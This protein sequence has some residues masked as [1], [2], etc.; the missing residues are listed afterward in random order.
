MPCHGEIITFPDVN[1][2]NAIRQK[3]NIP[4]PTP[5]TSEDMLQLTDLSASSKNISDLS[6]LEYAVNLVTLRLTYNQLNDV[7]GLPLL[8]N[9][10][11]LFLYHNQ[12]SDLAGFPDYPSLQTLWLNS[13]Q[14]SNAEVICPVLLVQGL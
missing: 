6:G 1:L 3:L 9:L 13:N 14:I 11:T 12:F 2:E 7:S 4:A 5:I 10:T 8:Q